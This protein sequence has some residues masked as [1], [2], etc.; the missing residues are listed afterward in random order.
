MTSMDYYEFYQMQYQMYQTMK[1]EITLRQL[2]MASVSMPRFEGF[3]GEREEIVDGEEEEIRRAKEYFLSSRTPS[4]ANLA[5]PQ[6]SH[7]TMVNDTT[8]PTTSTPPLPC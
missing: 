1:A 6:D 2:G 5:V 8:L 4:T 7:N 3:E